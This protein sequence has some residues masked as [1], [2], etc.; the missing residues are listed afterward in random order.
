MIHGL[1]PL[2]A[3]NAIVQSAIS[4]ERPIS[5]LQLQKIL[6]FSHAMCLVELGRPLIDGEFEAWNYGP[7]CR[8][9]YS[10][11]RRFGSRPISEAIEVK[12]PVT[13]ARIE[14]EGIP[15][16]FSTIIDRC[17]GFYSG[18]TPGQL[19]ELSHARGAPWDFVVEKSKREV[20]IG[21]RI[22][23]DVIVS[24]YR[25][26]WFNSDLSREKVIHGEDAPIT[27]Y[28]FC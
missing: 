18:M 8:E 15:N 25:F 1:D 19:V 5:H 13:G 27:A 6:Y 10:E 26:H 24:R 9:V 16:S 7:V 11:F 12:N 20:N 2:V 3:A 21:M 14:F 4:N 23:D 17:V 22:S 28:G